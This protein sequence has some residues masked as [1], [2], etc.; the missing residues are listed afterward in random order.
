M[1]AWI[2][3]PPD[4]QC[5]RCDR[6]TAPDCTCD[7]CNE[8]RERFGLEDYER[9]LPGSFG[10]NEP[11]TQ[12]NTHR[13]PSVVAYQDEALRLRESCNLS[14]NG[15]ADRMGWPRTTDRGY[16]VARWA[17]YQARRRR[18]DV[19]RAPTRRTRSSAPAAPRA[20][21]FGIEIEFNSHDYDVRSRVVATS[22][23]NGLN[24]RVED[25]GHAT[26]DYWKMVTDA[27]VSGGEFV[28]PPLPLS[29][30]RQVATALDAVREHGGT[31][32]ANQGMHVHHEV[33][34][35]DRTQM[36]NLL[37]TLRV[38]Q[39]A[40]MSAVPDSRYD[41]SNGC[42]ASFVSSYTWNDLENYA[43][44]EGLRVRGRQYR[45][46]LYVSRY[47]AFNFNA[48][49]AY[50]TVEFRGLGN[51]LNYAKVAAWT[52]VTGAVVEYVR[53]NL[54]VPTPVAGGLTTSDML[55]TLQDA[56]LIDV[57]TAGK[58]ADMARAERRETASNMLASVDPFAVA[59]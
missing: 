57:R 58:F 29:E 53:R 2:A 45:E 37:A 19:M 52:R 10:L 40:I 18:G 14:W 15:V 4:C 51:T 55:N 13:D 36:L 56:G 20:P 32:G 44:N 16:S 46:T 43:R 31:A 12:P 1:P 48:T 30:L 34:D 22:I 54:P 47:V 3:H 38:W 11:A 50:G 25:Y 17:A 33:A 59:A 39:A 28:S 21:R 9:G 35:L 6:Y 23:A 42:G 27:T 7:G 26:R 8:C 24:A 41:G 5:E 49:L